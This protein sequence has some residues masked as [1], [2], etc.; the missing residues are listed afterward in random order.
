[1]PNNFETSSNTVVA[2]FAKITLST[3]MSD[4]ENATNS[5]GCATACSLSNRSARLLKITKGFIAIKVNA[6]S[7]L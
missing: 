4:R 2:D 3:G 6:F 7:T 5:E 1:M